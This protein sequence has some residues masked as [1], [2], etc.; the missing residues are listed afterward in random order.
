[1]IGGGADTLRTDAVRAGEVDN[2]AKMILPTIDPAAVHEEALRL[3]VEPLRDLL[4]GRCVARHCGADRPRKDGL[5]P[6]LGDN[7][8]DGGPAELECKFRDERAAN[9]VHRSDPR[10]EHRCRQVGPVAFDQLRADAARE[11]RRRFLGE[12]SGEQPVRGEP[13]AYRR[14][15]PLDQRVGLAGARRRD[16]GVDAF[17]DTASHL[18]HASPLTRQSV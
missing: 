16:D 7:L 17:V 18:V 1:V 14:P 10:S 15:D 3:Q 12:G 9:A 6:V 13:R 11:L 8:G 4:Q 2:L 5:L